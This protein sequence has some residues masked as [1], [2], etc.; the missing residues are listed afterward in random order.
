MY[1]FP[2]LGQ[3]REQVEQTIF[4]ERKIRLPFAQET[5]DLRH[6]PV[7]LGFGRDDHWERAGKEGCVSAA[8][9][10]SSFN[11]TRATACT[12]GSLSRLGICFNRC[13]H[14]SIS[15]D[16]IPDGLTRG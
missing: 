5:V 7:V 12:V 2:V 11:D 16:H 13:S 6:R 10:R 4:F 3:R 1:L 8:A 14:L 15:P 9:E